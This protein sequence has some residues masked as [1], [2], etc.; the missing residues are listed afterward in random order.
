MRLRCLY[1][2]LM[3]L[4]ASFPVQTG[5]ASEN[6]IDDRYYY[7]LTNSYLGEA[8]SLDTGPDAPNAPFMAKSGN[9]SGQYWKLSFHGGCY[10]LT[11]MLLGPDR[12]LDTYSDGKNAPFMGRSGAESG[13][14]WHVTPAGDGYLRLTN[15]FLGNSRSLDTHSG[16]EHQP[17]MGGSDN[18][19]GQFWKL[20]RLTR[21]P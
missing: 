19:S 13:Q 11:N 6:A 9:Y 16:S 21:V 10:R 15:D 2:L 20:S 1:V 4:M 18:Y 3:V 5:A 8:Y 17:F 7:R 12:S 14:R